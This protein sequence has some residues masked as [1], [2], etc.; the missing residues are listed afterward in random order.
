MIA[1]K[2]GY[3]GVGWAHGIAA[4]LLLSSGVACGRLNHPP[5]EQTQK[6]LELLRTA[7]LIYRKDRGH[8]PSDPEGLSA[9]VGPYLDDE[10]ALND[11]W[12]HRAVY[13]RIEAT[14]KTAEAFI[15][16]SIGKNGI[17]EG[18][19]GD[20]IVVRSDSVPR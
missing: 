19:R 7:L 20:D 1:N 16:Y 17:D 3:H 10:Y 4:T 2:P 13:R 12:E 9:L 15:V 8:L 18:G 14:A 11:A 6:D 5:E